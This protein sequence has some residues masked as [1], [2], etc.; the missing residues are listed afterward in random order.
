MVL[1]DGLEWA[2]DGEALR[3]GPTDI[4]P[5][6]NGVVVIG[7]ALALVLGALTINYISITENET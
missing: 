2:E 1:E 4:V 5:G 6:G 7:A 3:D